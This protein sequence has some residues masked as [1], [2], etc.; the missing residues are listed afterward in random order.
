LAAL[1]LSGSGFVLDCSNERREYG[2]AS[3][4]AITCEIVPP[5]LRLPDSAAAITDGNNKVTIWPS[6]LE[7]SHQCEIR[8]NF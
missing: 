7:T 5:I 8:V 6:T 4:T 3:A 2:P 1:L